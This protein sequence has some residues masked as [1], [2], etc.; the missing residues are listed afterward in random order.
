MNHLFHKLDYAV[1]K[2]YKDNVTGRPYQSVYA[3]AIVK[4]IYHIQSS[5][6][7]LEKSAPRS[8]REYRQAG[9][10]KF[11]RSD[12]AITKNTCFIS[13]VFENT[14]SVPPSCLY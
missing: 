5:S 6:P 2:T 8:Q 13:E 11:D 10:Q 4:A 3:P 1:V 14:L 9:S 12:I 7:Q